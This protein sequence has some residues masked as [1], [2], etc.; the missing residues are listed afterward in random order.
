MAPRSSNPSPEGHL[1]RKLGGE[2]VSVCRQGADTRSHPLAYRNEPLAARGGG[3]FHCD[4]PTKLVPSAQF[5]RYR[6]HRRRHLFR[7]IHRLDG[8]RR[9]NHEIDRRLLGEF[10]SKRKQS[11]VSDTTI[12]RDLAF[13]GS[14]CAMAARWGW[15]DTD[16]VTSFGKRTLKEARPRT[17]FLTHA[18]YDVLLANAAE[19][20]RPATTLAVETGL[21][22]EELFGL[23]VSAIDLARR[24][25]RLDH[26]KRGV[27]RRV[28]LT[29]TAIATI[30]AMLG[31]SRRPKTPY[32]FAKA[33]GT[34]YADMKKGF[35]AACRRAKITGI[36]W[37]ALRHTFASW[38]VQSG[39]D[40]YHLSR[41]L[42]HSTVQMTTRVISAPETSMPSF[43]GW[44]RTGH[45]SISLRRPPDGLSRKYKGFQ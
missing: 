33:D 27:L 25:I 14:M 5:L 44:H 37:H 36:R 32:L 17:R 22:N 2:A 24:E 40:L 21:R 1:K 23:T 7:E 15:L 13:L 12:R 30:K 9:L 4:R 34:R 19:H 20:V 31:Q 45:R 43:A 18:E 35:N 39:G 10:V 38:F 16:P 8:H 3:E 28:P 11:G 41:I 42:G 29:D 26:T 6:S